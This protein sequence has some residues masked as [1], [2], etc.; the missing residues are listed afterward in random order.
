MEAAFVLHAG[1]AAAAKV[2]IQFSSCKHAGLELEC[3]D[4][5][6]EVIMTFRFTIAFIAVAALGACSTGSYRSSV[7]PASKFV[8]SAAYGKTPTSAAPMKSTWLGFLIQ[9]DLRPAASLTAH[10]F[11]AYYWYQGNEYEL[12]GNGTCS[13]RET[14]GGGA[15]GCVIYVNKSGYV[16]KSI[17]GL[18]TNYNATGCLAAIGHYKGNVTAY[19]AIHVRFRWTGYC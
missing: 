1:Q 5:P 2:I 14:S 10:S 3:A 9:D 13:L 6:A 4:I 12:I 17:V 19:K 16:Q 11:K 18:Y 8:P 15:T 7:N